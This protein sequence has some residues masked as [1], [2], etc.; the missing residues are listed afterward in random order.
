MLL[1]SPHEPLQAMWAQM[2]VLFLRMNLKLRMM[3]YN[4]A[5]ET[6]KVTTHHL[7]S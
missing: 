4:Q 5:M 7:G 6:R 1:K 3:K 2:T